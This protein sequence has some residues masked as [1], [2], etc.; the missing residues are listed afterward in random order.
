MRVRIVNTVEVP[1]WFRR[2][3]NRYYG[4]PG[5]ANREQVRDWFIAYGNSM[6]DD[7]A[8]EADKHQEEDMDAALG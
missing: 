6:D 4:K 2:E 8:M 7:L 5:L 1:D 3:I